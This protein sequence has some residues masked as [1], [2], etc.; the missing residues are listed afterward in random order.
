[1]VYRFHLVSWGSF[2]GD[3]FFPLSESLPLTLVRDGRDSEDRC[4]EDL[5]AR[6]EL[7]LGSDN[8]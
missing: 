2:R 8:S 7:S 6:E 5:P 1:M 4:G 3:E